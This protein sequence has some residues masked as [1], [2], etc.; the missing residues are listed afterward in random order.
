MHIINT[1][2]LTS[3]QYHDC[4]SL[5]ETC[6]Q[7]DNSRG[8]SFLEPEMNLVKEFPCFFLLY[9]NG[10]LISF[11]S[12]FI[13]DEMQCEIYA[14]TLPEQRNK[15]YFSKLLGLANEKL[16]EFNIKTIYLVNDPS[17]ITGTLA[18][19]KI[20][21]TLIDT[22][23]LM[24]YNMDITPIPKGI[25][26]IKSEIDGNTENFESFL[27]NTLIGHCYVEHSRATSVIFGFLID[28]QFRNRGFG[29]ET[30]LLILEKLLNDGCKKIL[31]HVNGANEAA[32]NMYFNHGFIH[33][34][35]IEYWML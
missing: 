19:N 16:E 1:N 20:G 21:A 7:A 17:S 18:L 14:N 29:T 9:D 3:N 10:S 30:L 15:G 28:E 4:R 8:I 6:K 22:D 23:Y 11:L 32:Y 13:P 12:V 31:L 2:T 33:E 35:K 5:I 24:R 25:L 26:N 27:D 34:E